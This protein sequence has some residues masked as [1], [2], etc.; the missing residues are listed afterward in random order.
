MKKTV[1]DIWMMLLIE[2]LVGVIVIWGA[3]YG[4]NYNASYRIAKVFSVPYVYT[5]TD[6][7][8]I[9][10][11]DELSDNGWTFLQCKYKS[12]NAHGITSSADKCVVI[13][14]DAPEY[15]LLHEIGHALYYTIGATSAQKIWLIAV[16]DDVL[17]DQE[18]QRDNLSEL[19]ANA[20]RNYM[21]TGK[22]KIEESWK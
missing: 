20:F 13:F 6:E 1:F 15:T 16:Q 2:L 22:C 9:E 11:I 10:Y 17:I 12:T 19:Y 4:N 18:Y 21:V 8:V 3:L 14:S 5:G 7:R